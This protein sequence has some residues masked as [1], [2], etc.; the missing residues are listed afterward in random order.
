MAL[1]LLEGRGFNGVA[2]AV[3][4]VGLIISGVAA[5]FAREAL[6]PP[7]RRLAIR[8]LAPAQLLRKGSD[9]VYGL[10][11]ERH[12]RVL[13]NPHIVTV[14][15]RNTGRHAVASND[16]DQ[17]RPIRIDLGAR[18]ETLLG[19]PPKQIFSVDGSS[20]LIGPDVFKRKVELVIQVLTS[21][22]PNFDRSSVSEHLVDA[23]VKVE[24]NRFSESV[25]IGSR[26]LRVSAITASA[27]MIIAILAILRDYFQ[28]KAG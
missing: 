10:E 6:F 20:L 18:V 25:D 17:G 9:E 12:G 1:D 2:L 27:G 8:I 16:F 4:L 5:Y 28:W 3:A 21:S 23:T 14:V 7:K 22:R 26:Q 24:V 19:P 11:I 15:I 13:E